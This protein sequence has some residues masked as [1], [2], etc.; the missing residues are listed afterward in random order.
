[1][2]AILAG[3][4]PSA[5]ASET[6]SDAVA[7]RTREWTVVLDRF[8]P[9]SPGAA[10]P[11]RLTVAATIEAQAASD[12]DSR[13]A[14]CAVRHHAVEV[15]AAADAPETS[16]LVSPV[17]ASARF[18][19]A[20]PESEQYTILVAA[21]GAAR[22]GAWWGRPVAAWAPMLRSADLLPSAED[23]CARK[24]TAAMPEMLEV[25]AAAS[26]LSAWIAAEGIGAVERAIG[27]GTPP[28]ETLRRYLAVAAA[29][30]DVRPARRALPPGELRGVTFAMANRSDG[31]YLSRRSAGALDRLKAD[32]ANGVAL[33]PYAFQRRATAPELRFPGRDPRGE[34]E[35]GVFRAAED[36]HRR[37][38]A[39]LVKPQIW[40]WRGFTGDIAMESEADWEAWFR[41]YRAYIVRFA[42]VA[43]AARAELFDVGVE[44]CASERRVREWRALAAAVRGATGAPLVYSCN[45]GKGASAVGFWD[46]LDAI[47]VDFYDPLS[48]AGN[49]TDGELSAGARAAMRPLADA[50]ARAG[51]P[52]YF[53]E[54]GFPSVAAAWLAPA[55]EETPRPFSTRDPARCARAIFSAAQGASWLRGMFWW[56]A[57]SD[58]REAQP[59]E[60]SFN[61]VGRPIENVIRAGFGRM[62]ASPP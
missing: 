14:T 17:L 12:G 28:V 30:P 48:P 53:T 1:M 38:L 31:S 56:K 36:A 6:A 33:V 11:V 25:G 52:V 32:G 5:V 23:L 57:F 62:A 21:Y 54:V 45:W 49:P 26:A 13:F 19:A 2:I 41:A 37:G 22:T 35:E 8:A 34:S 10:L 27:S 29:S 7:R 39:V 50:A 42:V 9:A 47:G 16:D 4:A 18:L 3:L 43:E 51:K 61:I 20:R 60:K 15:H 55:D 58:G 46:S 40:L 44:L 24:G 59:D